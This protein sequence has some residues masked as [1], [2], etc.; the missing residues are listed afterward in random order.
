[1]QKVLSYFGIIT[2]FHNPAFPNFPPEILPRPPLP[3][4]NTNNSD[5]HLIKNSL[6]FNSVYLI[7][8]FH[9]AIFLCIYTFACL[10][11]NQYWSK[12]FVSYSV[13]NPIAQKFIDGTEQCILDISAGRQ[14]SWAVTYVYLTRVLKKW[15]TYKYNIE[16]LWPPDVSK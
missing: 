9:Q 11:L 4:K 14:Q 13:K 7:N 3:I 2:K 8:L 12:L 5:F 15:T 1:M 16:E 10:K 6:S